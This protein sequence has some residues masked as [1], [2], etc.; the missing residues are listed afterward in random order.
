MQKHSDTP[1]DQPLADHSDTNFVRIGLLLIFSI[2]ILSWFGMS[3][4]KDHLE[5]R[6][7]TITIVELKDLIINSKYHEEALTSSAHLAALTGD[8]KWRSRYVQYKTSL[9]KLIT[10]AITSS[11]NNDFSNDAIGAKEA[12]S[13]L[14]SLEEAVFGHALAG[15]L[16]LGL[17]IL[18]STEYINQREKYTHYTNAIHTDLKTIVSD[19]LKIHH[20]R[21]VNQNIIILFLAI[22]MII[23]WILALRRMHRDKLKLSKLNAI[24][25]QSAIQANAASEAKSM[26]LANMSHEIRTPLTAIMGFAELMRNTESDFTD[27]ENLDHLETIYHNSKQLL[28][29]INDVLDLSKIEAGKMNVES[30]PVS[31]NQ[32]TDDLI[33]LMWIRA[34]SKSITLDARYSTA[35]PDFILTDPT[36]L[37]QILFNLVGNA[38]KFTNSGGVTVQISADESKKLIWLS[39]EDTG[40]GIPAQDADRIFESFTQADETTT[41]KAGGTGLG[42]H[43]CSQLIKMLGGTIDFESTLG[44]GSRFMISIPFGVA[45][46]KMIQPNHIEAAQ[47]HS[48]LKPKPISQPQAALLNGIRILLV[49][50]GP[51]NRMLISRLLTKSGA[52]VSCANNGREAVDI[53]NASLVE[54]DLILMDMQMPV[55]DGYQATQTLRSQDFSIPII[56]LTAHSLTEDRKKCMDAGCDD[57][58]TKPIDT[59]KLVQMCREWSRQTERSMVQAL[60]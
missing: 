57:Y 42:L 31:I 12:Y 58:F 43:I 53:I 40:T 6:E 14:V 3:A 8:P 47:Y 45:H 5:S 36:R 54:F 21:A 9:N 56:A 4:W 20:R 32:L 18:Q 16:D 23:V 2:S 50:D 33:S 55:L 13:A 15:K 59:P 52:D 26:F 19:R 34:D 30:I 35:I 60:D 41:R 11:P 10:E 48:N 51:D 17:S 27:V 39:I 29:I 1:T 44:I 49:E 25:N 28:A 38:I 37:R 46:Y 7:L 24:A 22:V